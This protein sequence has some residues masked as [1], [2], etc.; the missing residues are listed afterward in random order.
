MKKRNRTLSLGLTLL[1]IS[2][3][4][5]GCAP[6]MRTVV[7]DAKNTLFPPRFGFFIVNYPS[8]N[9]DS[10]KGDFYAR[11]RYDDVVFVKTDSGY[12]AHYQFSINVFSNKDLTELRYSQIFERRLYV[13]T[14]AQTNSTAMFDTVKDKLT[15]MPGKYY[16]VLKLLDL[17]TNLASY[18]EFKHTFKNFLQYPANISDILLY[19]RSDTSGIPI[20]IVRNRLDSLYAEFYVTSKIVPAKISLHVIAKSVE[21][22]TSID[23]TYELAQTA[24]VQR[25]RMPIEVMD[26]AAGTYN[27][28][29][30]VKE[31]SLA[32]GP[33]GK[34]NSSETSFEVLRSKIPLVPAELDQEIEPLIYITTSD[35]VASLKK[36]TFEERQKKFMEFWLARA[37]GDKAAADA[38]RNEFYK[39]VD[40]ANEHLRGGAIKGW[41][42]DRGR[43]YIIYGPPDQVE[44]HN[45]NFNSPPYQVWYYYSLRLRFVFLD[46]FGTGDYRLVETS[47][48]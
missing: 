34:E 21:V 8:Q 24:N 23:T 16:L 11:I 25:Y 33:G 43:I 41:Q 28:K 12:A 5:A 3:L 15:L 7:P 2:I 36:G 14:Y 32:K 47:G 6:E 42:T 20:D 31:E 29:V 48:T 40:F 13:P 4:A 22:P 19:D 10:S 35:E 44:T 26:L 27:L 46:E 17:N 30:S 39:R 38:M 45:E 37:H 1:M 9:S 18:R